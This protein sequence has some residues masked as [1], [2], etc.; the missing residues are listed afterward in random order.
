MYYLENYL[1][2]HKKLDKYFMTLGMVSWKQLVIRYNNHPPINYSIDP[3]HSKAFQSNVISS[4]KPFEI[5]KKKQ[6]TFFIPSMY[7]T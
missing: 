7:S 5:K 3:Y 6:G 2:L 1:T 4:Y